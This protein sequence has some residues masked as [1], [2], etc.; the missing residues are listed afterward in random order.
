LLDEQL[1]YPQHLIEHQL[2]HNV[3][4]AN[5]CAYNRT[6]HLKDRQEMMQ[7]WSGFLA[8]LLHL[9][10]AKQAKD[11]VRA[12]ARVGGKSLTAKNFLPLRMK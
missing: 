9:Y 6:T 7:A 10:R 5:G 3:K 4:D 8:P 2:S 11:K 1:G 12:R